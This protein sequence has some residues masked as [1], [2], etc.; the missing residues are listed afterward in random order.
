MQRR[1]SS[2][3]AITPDRAVRVVFDPDETVCLRPGW[4]MCRDAGEIARGSQVGVGSSTNVELVSDRWQLKAVQ[5]DLHT[6]NEETNFQDL[7]IP[8]TAF[9]YAVPFG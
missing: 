1:F 9:N 8:A 7:V 3:Q 2:D 5:A 6:I 4:G